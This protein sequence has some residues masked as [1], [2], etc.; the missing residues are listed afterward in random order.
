MRV[1]EY[2]YLIDLIVQ[3]GLTRHWLPSVLHGSSLDLRKE[4]ASSNAPSSDSRSTPSPDADAMAGDY[5]LQC[6]M[7]VTGV[8]VGTGVTGTKS[9]SHLEPSKA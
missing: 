3:L 8:T 7:V 4:S 6:H 9:L 2:E 5:Q 1:P